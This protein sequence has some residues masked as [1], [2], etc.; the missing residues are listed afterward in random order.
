MR[1]QELGWS[2]PGEIYHNGFLVIIHENAEK[3][4]S[5]G[6]PDN[7]LDLNIS[8]LEVSNLHVLSLLKL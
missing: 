7:L 2:I 8:V 6:F 1:G 3:F 5:H 4:I